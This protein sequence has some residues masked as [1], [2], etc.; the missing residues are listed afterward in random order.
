MNENNNE[1]S[2][3]KS[4]GSVD[5]DAFK[6]LA[7][8]LLKNEKSMGSLMNLATTFLK[9]DSLLNSIESNGSLK[10]PKNPVS[11][12]VEEQE[13]KVTSLI[14]MHESLAK[15]ISSFSQKLDTIAKEISEL[16]KEWQSLKEHNPKLFKKSK[17]SS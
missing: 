7:G 15:Q 1:K 10:N 2:I 6:N 13:D 12:D 9:N 11:I 8:N 16:T 3:E 4:G 14:K 17:K 5:H